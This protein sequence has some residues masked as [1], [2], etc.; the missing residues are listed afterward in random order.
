MCVSAAKKPTKTAVDTILGV[1]KR[2]KKGVDTTALM[3]KT[4]YNAKKVRNI[5]FNLKKQGKIKSEVM[6]I[7][8]L[9]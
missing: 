1:I 9:A 2:S 6:G 3:K 4:G 5:I 8:L 7:Y